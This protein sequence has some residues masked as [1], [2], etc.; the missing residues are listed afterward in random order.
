[1]STP[2]IRGPVPPFS[3]VNIA[4]QNYEPSRFAISAITLGVTT[5]V[6]TSVN[7]NYVIGQEVR[8]IIPP[9]FG[10]RQL[11]EVKGNVL[12]IPAANQV[13]TNINSSKN[14]DPFVSSSATT[15][16]QI[17]AVGD[18]NTGAINTSGRSPTGTFI[19]GSFINISP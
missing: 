12:S 1:M 7:H 9:S 4:P 3:N 13:T 16:A 2:A 8:L 6:T 17:L 18:V 11:N 19:P 15:V 10:S 5:T 14:V